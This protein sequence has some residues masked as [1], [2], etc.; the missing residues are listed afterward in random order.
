MN[1]TESVLKP[2]SPIA[3]D[4]N[5]IPGRQESVW[6]MWPDARHLPTADLEAVRE[7]FAAL[8]RAIA[9]RDPVLYRQR[10]ETL[11]VIVAAAEERQAVQKAL[12]GLRFRIHVIPNAGVPQSGQLGA[13]EAPGL[14]AIPSPGPVLSFD[15]RELPASYLDFYVGRTTV[16]VPTFGSPADRQAIATI[17]G[18]FPAKRSVGVSAI[19]LLRAGWTLS[20]VAMPSSAIW[21]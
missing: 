13:R 2:Q 10:G 20:Q 12:D 16:V 18:F 19:A 5:E 4:R 8:C 7:E 14:T 1:P 11:D 3:H 17:G 15:G 9:D 6:L 21:S